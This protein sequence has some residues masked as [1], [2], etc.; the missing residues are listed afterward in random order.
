MRVLLCHNYYTQAGGEDQVFHSELDL[1][2]RNGYEAQAYTVSNDQIAHWC[3]PR[4]WLASAWN[5]GVYWELGRILRQFRPHV[6]HV[7]NFFAVLSPSVYWAARNAGAAV[8]QTFHNFRLICPQATFL[9]EGR[10]CEDCLEARSYLPA[11]RHRCYRGAFVPTFGLSAA[12]GLHW[13]AG[14]WP[15]MIDRA[16]VLS[17]FARGK[18][19]AA[20]LPADR[21]CVK[22][23]TLSADPG[24]R[25]G[26]GQYYLYAGRLSEEKGIGLLLAVWRNGPELPPLLVAG[27]GPLEGSVS[28]HAAAAG[29]IR[30]LGP[31]P[32]SE[33]L[34]LLQGARA[35]VIP[36]R[37][38]ES[39]PMVLAEAMA[40][41]VPVIAPAHGPFPEVIEPGRHGYLFV[42]G[43]DG[44]LAEA[45]RH[46]EAAPDAWEPMSA[47]C[48]QQYLRLC[49]P[50]AGM[51]ALA[52]IYQDAME[53]AATAA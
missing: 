21:L 16:I 46:M 51:R 40:C 28:R 6:V 26:P 42:P 15:G 37:C 30:P 31:L 5:P 34:R 27:E 23:N 9:R 8:V 14:T 2:R 12:F 10:P 41:G 25:H 36:S 13:F 29:N 44:S 38:Y 7:H 52:R 19:A 4:A 18:F 20:G 50:E 53:R 33:V 47:A 17:H 1:L 45:V 22:Y 43:G 11:V 35:L 49:S 48:R 39:F 32:R 3:K 24:P